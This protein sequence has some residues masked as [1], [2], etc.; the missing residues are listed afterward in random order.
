DP[1]KWELADFAAFG[2]GIG[3]DPLTYL[4]GGLSA[5]GKAGKIAKAAGLADDAVKVASKAAGKTV[6]KRA[7]RMNTR[8]GDLLEEAPGAYEPAEVPKAQP[9][10]EA[11]GTT[12]DERR[13]DQLGGLRGIG[14]PVRD[15]SIVVGRQ[16]NKLAEGIASGLDT[17]GSAIRQGNIPGTSF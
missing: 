4:A 5:V 11:A 6:G 3:L 10:A 13:G 7:A 9:A 2:V 12:Q 14:R 15:P 17:V 8:L 1:N 16:A